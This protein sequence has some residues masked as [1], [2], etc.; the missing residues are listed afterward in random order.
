MQLSD[1]TLD[2]NIQPIIVTDTGC[3]CLTNVHLC[4]FFKP[5]IGSG[6]KPQYTT[7]TFGEK[8]SLYRIE[9]NGPRYVI[10]TCQDPLTIC[11]TYLDRIEPH[12]LFQACE[13]AK[14]WAFT[15]QEFRSIIVFDLDETLINENGIPLN[16]SQKVL[17][18]AREIFDIVVLYSHGSNLHV[19]EHILQFRNSIM[20]ND[21]PL[22]DLVLS[23]NELD[24]RS[25]KNLLYLYNYFP[26]IRFKNATLVDD[27]MFNW[28]PEYKNII[29][30]T[31]QSLHNMLKILDTS[32]LNS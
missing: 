22:F 23:K 31:T 14:L 11:A 4:K 8:T 1:L 30:P 17:K 25:A 9:E 15:I 18:R 21:A 26:N 12:D 24:H 13:R 3:K 5:Y 16:H 2:S 6:I 32:C 19:D 27:S 10:W 20:L 7:Y 29:I 28:T